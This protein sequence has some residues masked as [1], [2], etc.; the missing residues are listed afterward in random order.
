[1]LVISLPRRGAHGCPPTQGPAS[2]GSG[3]GWSRGGTEHTQVPFGML[4]AVLL[5]LYPISVLS[6][7]AFF[8]ESCQQSWDL[9]SH[10]GSCGVNPGANPL[11]FAALCG[12]SSRR[13][14][15]S[16]STGRGRSRWSRSTEE[17]LGC[18]LSW[19]AEELLGTGMGRGDGVQWERRGAPHGPGPAGIEGLRFWEGRGGGGW[20]GMSPAEWRGM[21][22][23]LLA[24]PHTRPCPGARLLSRLLL[25]FC[26]GKSSF[27]FPK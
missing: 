13:V 25:H 11:L 23:D 2:A 10:S 19:G 17:R 22:R 4:G 18:A 15:V 27:C 5:I 20:C 26:S 12:K 3:S 7:A 14:Y 1:M 6:L 16:P 24:P 9:L 21:L 8:W